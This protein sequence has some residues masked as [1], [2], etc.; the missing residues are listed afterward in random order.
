MS[1]CS[2]SKIG[3]TDRFAA[4]SGNSAR[5]GGAIE[6]RGKSEPKRALCCGETV[7]ITFSSSCCP[8]VVPRASSADLS[9][10]RRFVVVS[11][12]CCPAQAIGAQSRFS[13]QTARRSIHHGC[14]PATSPRRSWRSALTLLPP[15]P[16][17]LTA[18]LSR[19]ILVVAFLA[20]LLS[21]MHS[22][23]VEAALEAAVA[24]SIMSDCIFAHIVAF[25]GLYLYCS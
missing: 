7:R 9:T 10:R 23:S 21:R 1:S 6:T 4:E 15:P 11:S 3:L 24:A 14:F 18:V 25:C 12:S 13:A 16:S 8:S 19:V 17:S 5:R 22:C 2:P 20:A